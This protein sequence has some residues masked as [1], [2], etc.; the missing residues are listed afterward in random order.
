MVVDVD[1]LSMLLL[2]G[3]LT[4]PRLASGAS[5]SE[6]WAWVRYL[7]AISSSADLRV[8]NEFADLDSHQKT[9]LSDDFG[10]GI[11]MSWLIK[12]L[13]LTAWCD[14][15]DFISRFTALTKVPPRKPKNRGPT[16]SPDFVCLD[17]HGKFHIIECKGTQCGTAAREHQLSHIATNGTPSGGIVQKRMIVLQPSFRGQRLACGV[18]IEREGGKGVS[19]LRIVDPEGEIPL[20]I[21]ADKVTTA[22]DPILRGS[23]ARALRSAGLQ[24]SADVIAA[25]SGETPGV[26]SEM[27]SRPRRVETA[28]REFVQERRERAQAELVEAAKVQSF[29][30]QNAAFVGRQVQLDLPR[31]LLVDGKFYRSVVIRQGIRLEALKRISGEA[32]DD[33]PITECA[34]WLS[35]ELGRATLSRDGA[36]A[37]LQ[38][39]GLFFS[40][41]RLA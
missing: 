6:F 12:P 2:V 25:P 7:Y 22:Y 18:N 23:L 9:I 21:D 15:R 32:L 19:D 5:L 13:E 30:W 29:Q 28:R 37:D 10:M 1:V 36:G 38:L 33:R 26:Q 39:G 14:G 8:T 34:P 3:H 20:E 31:S 35:S 16:K 24:V 27:N 41:L 17:K 4:T 40:D 11:P